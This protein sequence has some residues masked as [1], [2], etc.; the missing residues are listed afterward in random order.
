VKE[1]SS[2]LRQA[3]KY[4]A[5]KEQECD[6]VTLE[7]DKLKRELKQLKHELAELKD[8]SESCNKQMRQEISDLKGDC[9]DLTELVKT[10]D[11]MLEDQL[12]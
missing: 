2:K 3:E 8:G 4:L 9:L 1:T 10:K 5:E 6:R 11:R 7:N 12:S